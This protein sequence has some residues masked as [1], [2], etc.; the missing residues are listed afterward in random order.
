LDRWFHLVALT[1]RYTTDTRI[2]M[3]FRFTESQLDQKKSEYCDEEFR[4]GIFVPIC[5]DCAGLITDLVLNLSSSFTDMQLHA[6]SLRP[7]N[8]SIQSMTTDSTRVNALLATLEAGKRYLDTVINLPV[9]EYH[10]LSFVQW[11]RLPGVII[12]LARLCIPSDSLVE[13]QWDVKMAHDRV[14]L[15]LYLDSLCYRMQSLTIHSR[16]NGTPVDFWFA[17]KMIMEPTRDWF[18]RKINTKSATSTSTTSALPTPDTMQSSGD[19]SGDGCPVTDPGRGAFGMNG[20]LGDLDMGSNSNGSA[21]G[22]YGFMKDPNFDME[23]FFDMG[24]WGDE[25][26]V[27]MGF[28]GGRRF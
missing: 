21:G 20:M 19:G 7:L 22:A 1:T 3:N 6:I 14:R 23:I 8:A 24:L 26:Y 12:T 27:G 9:S 2:M 10:L 25:S 18:V 5:Y 15:D 4:H 16:S 28:G 13:A 17:M 11:M